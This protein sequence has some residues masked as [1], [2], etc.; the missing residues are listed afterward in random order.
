MAP[1]GTAP[2][3]DI[4]TSFGMAPRDPPAAPPLKPLCVNIK[5]KGINK[6]MSKN[7][8][9]KGVKQRGQQKGSNKGVNKKGA[10][11]DVKK[12]VD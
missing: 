11:K 5:I 7:R 1:F 8:S 9:T 6:K 3:A 2:V 10:R 12:G 4:W